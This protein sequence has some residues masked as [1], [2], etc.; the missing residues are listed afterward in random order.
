MICDCADVIVMEQIYQVTDIVP[1]QQQLTL[2]S[3]KVV[4]ES[5]DLTIAQCGI[6]SGDTLLLE[7]KEESKEILDGKRP[8]P[9][10]PSHKMAFVF[11]FLKFNWKMWWLLLRRKVSKVRLFSSF[12]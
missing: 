10:P 4:L 3:T 7:K 2:M 1:F 5:D 6:F 8:F 9:L 11:F 12:F